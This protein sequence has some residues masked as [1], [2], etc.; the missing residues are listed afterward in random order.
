MRGLN[1]LLS[2]RGTRRL[3]LLGMRRWLTEGF[4]DDFKKAKAEHEQIRAD[5]E[6]LQ[7]KIADEKSA[8]LLL[9]E[10]LENMDKVAKIIASTKSMS[11]LDFCIK[12][13]FSNFFVD[14]KNVVSARLSE[15][16]ARLN[17]SE[18]ALGAPCKARTCDLTRV[19][20]A[21]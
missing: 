10:F 2:G 20:G 8:I 11:E 5:I 18:V 1:V 4:K 9:P 14:K 16:F 19:K 7:A 17:G 3:Y 12:K 13:V 15:P 6:K 21:L